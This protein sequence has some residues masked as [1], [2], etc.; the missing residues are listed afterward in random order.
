MREKIRLADLSVLYVCLSSEWGTTERRCISDATY[1]RNIGGSAFILCLEKSLIDR[2]A[3]R[4]DLPRLYFAGDLKSWRSILNFYFQLQHILQ[5]KQVD[6]VHTYNYE[7]LLPLGIILKGLSHIPLVY[8]YNKSIKYRKLSILHRWFMSRTDTIFTFSE[9]IKEMALEI[10]PVHKKKI[11]LTGIGIEL[12]QK[13]DK[14]VTLNDIRKVVIF[15]QRTE[16]DLEKVKLFINS[17]LPVLHQMSAMDKGQRLIFTFMTDIP[18][19]DHPIYD[20]LKR[21]ILERHL[22]MSISFDTK[23]LGGNAF[24]GYDIYI[25]L[26]HSELFADQDLF[27]LAGQLPVLLPRTST[28]Q[29]L[30]KQGKLGETYFPG[31]GREIK[32]KL[33]K[34]LSNYSSYL[35]EIQGIE[36]QIKELHHYEKYAEE[37]YGHYE[38]LCAQRLRYAQKKKKLA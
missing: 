13:N 25:G 29:H 12:P 3:E 2:E 31:D 10:F 26:P 1:F 22:E 36:T 11:Q 7:S 4:E 28:C 5:K 16:N 35:E 37:L 8:T 19:F 33:L 34:I 20:E 32:D 9:N 15:I 18:W 30:V 21:V 24:N 23:K 17:I 38:R 14:K 27:A 6:F